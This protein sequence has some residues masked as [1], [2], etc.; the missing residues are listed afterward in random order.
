M[1]IEIYVDNKLYAARK[2]P[3]VPRQGDLIQLGID[4]YKI[5]MV[6][7]CEPD[8]GEQVNLFTTKYKTKT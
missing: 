3:L 1:K 7:W 8:N 4:L 6:V 5:E 2:M